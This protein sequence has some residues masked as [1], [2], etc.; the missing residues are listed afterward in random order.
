LVAEAKGRECTVVDG[1]WIEEMLIP[2][3]GCDSAVVCALDVDVAENVMTA[4]PGPLISATSAQT[5]GKPVA[6]DTSRTFAI[7]EGADFEL[8]FESFPAR[9]ATCV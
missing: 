6:L 5:L 7:R 4:A 3:C 1:P 2:T 9:S 8:F